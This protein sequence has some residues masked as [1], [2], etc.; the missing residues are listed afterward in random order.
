MDT[1]FKVFLSFLA[2]VVIFASGL[3]FSIS[4]AAEIETNN[5][6]ETT[7]KAVIESNYNE[8]VI[9]TLIEEA[10]LHGHELTIEV[11]GAD[12]PG[13]NKYADIRLKYSYEVK[14][15]NISIERTKQKVL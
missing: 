8:E 4:N 14:L 12:Y 9:D 6:F 2:V 15:F 5:Y 7:S 1:W 3:S 10:A 11:Y 13:S